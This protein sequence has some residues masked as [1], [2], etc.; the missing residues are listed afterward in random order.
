[1]RLRRRSE[2][3][4]GLQIAPLIDIVFLLLIYFMVSSTIQ[5]SEA[6][7]VLRLPGTASADV[8]L[9]LPEEQVVEIRAD[10][11]VVVNERALDRPGDA[12]F[13]E[14][15]GLLVRFR[16]SVVAARGVPALLIAPEGGAPHAA[17]VRVLDAAAAAGVEQVTFAL[18]DG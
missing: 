12:E 17:T 8:S 1:M 9:E 3:V 13:R 18:D 14:L 2:P 5:R 6:D 11:Q 4:P 15:A 10:G 7:L 16:A